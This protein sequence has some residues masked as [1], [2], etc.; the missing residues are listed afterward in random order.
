MKFTIPFTGRSTTYKILCSAILALMV[1][2]PG[3]LSAQSYVIGVQDFEEYLPYSTYNDGDYTGFNRE[4]LDLFASVKGYSFEY[5]ALPIKRLYADFL[6]GRVDL[7]YPDSPFWSRDI[8]EGI[9]V[10]YSEPLVEYIDG[11]IV[12]TEKLNAGVESL[13]TLGM[14]GGFTPFAYLGLI[15]EKKISLQEL[16]SIE[17]LLRQVNAGRIDGAYLNTM[18]SQYYIEKTLARGT[19]LDFDPGLPHSR[20]TR[21]LSTIKHPE[22]LNSFNN[23]LVEY[24]DK[25]EE[26][27]RKYKVLLDS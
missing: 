17:G 14:I 3:T 6:E 19:K 16:T 15:N 13:K 5:R 27:K 10:I 20:G 8:K 11:V 24:K 18:V 21:H 2:I 1:L 26:L 7:K 22:L 23:F 25:V 4:L 9:D 12:K